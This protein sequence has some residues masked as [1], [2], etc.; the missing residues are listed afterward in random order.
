MLQVYALDVIRFC[1]CPLSAVIMYG[2]IR[3]PHRCHL[4]VLLLSRYA[5]E[6]KNR[7]FLSIEAFGST[8][9]HC[10]KLF[11]LL[12]EGYMC[13][14]AL[15]NEEWV[16]TAAH[17]LFKFGKR[18]PHFRIDQMKLIFGKHHYSKYDDGELTISASK[19]IEHPLFLNGSLGPSFMPS[20]DIAL[21][22]LSRKLNFDQVPFSKIHLPPKFSEKQ[23]I[24]SFTDC[25]IIGWGITDPD[26]MT[27]P[28]NL[29]LQEVDVEF[30]SPAACSRFY[31]HEGGVSK[32]K[33]CV[34]G[35][36]RKNACNG[37]SGGP[38]QCRAKIDGIDQW[39]VVG[40]VSGGMLCGSTVHPIFSTSVTQVLDWISE[41]LKNN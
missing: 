36:S 40:V 11:K 9:V 19:H 37:D 16:L 5:H 32:E 27:R 24:D 12:I 31:S 10:S 18:Y 17:C 14:G 20:Y 8:H 35:A 30:M 25:K 22:K 29:V 1:F 38:L 33:I 21:V 15:I 26:K 39:A 13:G 7:M 28:A 6:C 23:S 41:T 34:D 2:R 4:V 3:G